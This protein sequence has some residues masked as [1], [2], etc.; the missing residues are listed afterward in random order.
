SLLESTAEDQVYRLELD[1]SG[2]GTVVFG[3]GVF[4]QSPSETST[5]TAIYR[6]GGGT[7]GRHPDTGPAART[8]FATARARFPAFPAV[9]P[10]V[11][12]IAR[13]PPLPPS[14]VMV[15]PPLPPVATPA[16]PR[17]HGLFDRR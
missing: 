13:Q 9:P 5:V 12:R 1:D 8:V 2:D 6:V 11:V 15:T 4:G 14:A 16:K 17:R 7:G 3:D 10:L